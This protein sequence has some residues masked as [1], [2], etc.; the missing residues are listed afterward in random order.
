MEDQKILFYKLKKVK[1]HKEMSAKKGI[2]R[3]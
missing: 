3:Y 1:I 2:K